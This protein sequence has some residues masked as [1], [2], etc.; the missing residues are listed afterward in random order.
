M[1][2]IGCTCLEAIL[3]CK[4]TQKAGV[5]GP[6]GN[7][8]SGNEEEIKQMKME[9]REMILDIKS[10]D[11]LEKVQPDFAKWASQY[12]GIFMF[13]SGKKPKLHISDPE[14]AKQVLSNKF[15]F[16]RKIDVGPG[17][18]A[19][20]GKGLVLAEGAD[21]ARHRRVVSPAFTMDKLKTMTGT[22]ADCAEAMLTNWNEKKEVE[23][24]L[25]F[26][27]LTAN[28][29]SHTA[30]GSSYALGKEVFLAQKELQ[31]IIITSFFKRQFPFNKYLPT[32]ANRSRRRLERKMRDTLMDIIERR[33]ESKE[34]AYGEDLLGL[35]M[36]ACMS[37]N[38]MTMDEIIS[39]C[40]TFFFA[41][42]E[43][44]SHLLTWTIFLLSTHQEWQQR[45]R[46]EVLRE[47]GKETPDADKISKLKLMTMVLFEVLRLYSP[48][49]VLGRTAI[50]DV[51][52][53]SLVVPKDMDIII[54]VAG[55]HHS[56]EIWGADAN[57]FN[58]LRFENGVTKAANHPNAML[59]FSTGPRACV[60]QSFAMLEAKIVLSMILQKFSF[61][62]SPDYKHMPADMLTLQPQ[63]G[64]PILLQN[65]SA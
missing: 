59:A 2:S 8:W 41:G 9:R 20:L 48:V 46:E 45:L 6:K 58:P 49:M 23:V 65:L 57:E 40:K 3:G 37:G 27:E 11:F 32:E 56:K 39:E 31:M 51:K 13:W 63:R 10:H 21:W 16:Y 35:M 61:V 52:L 50:K 62:L 33:L 26:Q 54:P 7:F 29:I 55:I 44:T 15:G 19:L 22:I 36:Q 24:S 53:G 43:T 42:H 34:A 47:C 38:T 12:G 30:F 60:G 4:K 18:M 5:K 14:L 28:A 17:I 25:E 64:L 1:E